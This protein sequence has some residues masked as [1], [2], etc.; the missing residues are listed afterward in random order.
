MRGE[1]TV[2]IIN[3]IELPSFLPPGWIGLKEHK[4]DRRFFEW[5]PDKIELYHPIVD[6]CL[7]CVN[8]YYFSS[9][10]ERPLNANVLDYL[11]K[12]PELIP[13]K[14]RDYAILFFGT[15]YKR[16]NDCICVRFLRWDGTKWIWGYMPLKWNEFFTNCRAV[17][18][19]K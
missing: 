2:H 14:W 13:E 9:C 5:N 7:E 17:V 12:N 10:V 1:E 3:C 6:S 8:G 19:K 18:I 4:S 15:T 11:L 16:S